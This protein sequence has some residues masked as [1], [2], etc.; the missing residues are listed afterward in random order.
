MT[1]E[2]DFEKVEGKSKTLIRKEIE[3]WDVVDPLSVSDAAY[4]WCRL[5]PLPQFEVL[6]PKPYQIAKRIWAIATKLGV[7]QSGT[8]FMPA[9]EFTR[10]D[11]KKMAEK[12]GE[13]PD[14]LYPEKRKTRKRLRRGS[15]L[16]TVDLH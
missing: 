11:L 15:S 2:T 1:I 4:L 3:R 13:A 6:P 16:G 14:F 9:Q 8:F 10:T 5:V 12:L 7:V